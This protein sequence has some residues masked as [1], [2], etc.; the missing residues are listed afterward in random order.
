MSERPLL[1]P[2]L[3]EAAAYYIASEALTNVAKHAAAGRALVAVTWNDDAVCVEVVDDGAGGA[4]PAAGS[5]LVGLRDRVD[6]LGGSLSIHSPRG[7]GTT[8]RALLPPQ[9]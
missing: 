2:V 7:E 5:G 6:S 8:V 9:A 1:E 3:Q 4:D